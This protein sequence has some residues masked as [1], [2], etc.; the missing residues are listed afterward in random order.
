MNVQRLLILAGMV[1]V[2]SFGVL[3]LTRNYHGNWLLAHVT[4]GAV[5]MPAYYWFVARQKQ[6]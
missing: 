6:R 2:L 5:F 4:Y 1:Y 3:L